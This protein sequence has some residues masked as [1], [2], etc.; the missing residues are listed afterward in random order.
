MKNI[1][2]FPY[3]RVWESKKIKLPTSE[4][5]LLSDIETKGWLGVGKLIVNRENVFF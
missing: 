2:F 5:V 4:P 3:D 1:S